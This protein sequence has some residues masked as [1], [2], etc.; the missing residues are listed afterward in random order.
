M[1]LDGRGW[2]FGGVAC[3]G[4]RSGRCK[5]RALPR[6]WA[7]YRW[8][9]LPGG[10]DPTEQEMRALSDCPELA[11]WS[12]SGCAIVVLI[13]YQPTCTRLDLLPTLEPE[14]ERL[15]SR[16]PIALEHLR[17]QAVGPQITVDRP[18]HRHSAC[19]WE[20]SSVCCS[21]ARSQFP[22]RTCAAGTPALAGTPP[23]VNRQSSSNSSYIHPLWCA[24]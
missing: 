1:R 6:A 16:S 12:T 13:E 17:R 24:S 18:P 11:Q 8:I 2:T 14:R 3:S 5:H 7:S 23:S 22:L 19:A 10:V 20:N 15:Y 9:M 4:R 21:F